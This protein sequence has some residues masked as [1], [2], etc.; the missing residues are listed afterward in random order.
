[1]IKAD[2]QSLSQ[3]TGVCG[4]GIND[5]DYK[6]FVEGVMC[7]FYHK[8]KHMITRCYSGRRK[9][10]IGCTVCDEW[11][12]FSNFKA[13]MNTQDWEGK[14]LDKDIIKQGNRVYS[15]DTCVFVTQQVNK[16]LTDSKSARGRY[17]IGVSKRK[18][19]RVN[20]YQASIGIHSKQAHLGYFDTPEKAHQAWVKAKSELLKE[21]AYKQ[22]DFRV[23]EALLKRANKMLTMDLK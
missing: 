11:L 12:L 6:V 18:D 9:H 2:K 20:Q 1:M 15:P 14:D 21:T 13:W 7:P 3:R 17:P 5:A 4:V 16:L 23:K 19:K 22:S 10:Y 8:W